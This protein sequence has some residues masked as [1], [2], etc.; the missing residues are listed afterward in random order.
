[1]KITLLAVALS[2]T[3]LSQASSVPANPAYEAARCLGWSKAD[4][5]DMAERLSIYDRTDGHVR[6]TYVRARGGTCEFLTGYDYNIVRASF[7]DRHEDGFETVFR[8]A[9]TDTA[10]VYAGY[11]HQAEL[12][13]SPGLYGYVHGY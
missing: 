10:G 6:W 4:A 8:L 9:E 3:V 11:T 12:G 13:I 5:A 1:M 7:L 2:A